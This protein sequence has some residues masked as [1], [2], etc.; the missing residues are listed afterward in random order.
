MGVVF[1]CRTNSEQIFWLINASQFSGYHSSLRE[2][3]KMRWMFQA[4]WIISSHLVVGDIKLQSQRTYLLSDFIP[5]NAS[6]IAESRHLWQQTLKFWPI[7]AQNT[8][9]LHP[10]LMFRKLQNISSLNVLGTH[11]KGGICF[12]VKRS[13]MIRNWYNQIPNPALKT[14]REITKYINWQQFTKRTHG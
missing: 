12:E 13:A 5:D 6:K 3:L 1:L 4:Y 10:L 7:D 11:N 14:K 9:T 8:P 2:D